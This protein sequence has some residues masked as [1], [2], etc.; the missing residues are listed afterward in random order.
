MKRG[1]NIDGLVKLPEAM[2]VLSVCRA[3]LYNLMGSGELPFVKIGKL[4]RVRMSALMELIERNTH[5]GE[6]ASC[7]ATPRNR[8]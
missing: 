3:T 2:R 5:G 4:R 6:V 7:K 1:T 8:S